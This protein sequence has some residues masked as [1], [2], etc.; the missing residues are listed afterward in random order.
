MTAIIGSLIIFCFCPL[1]GGLPLIDWLTYV[2]KGQKL[3]EM[4]TGNVSV[5]AAFYHGGT[6]VGILAVLSEAGKGVFTVLLARYFFPGEMWWE[7]MA[8]IALIIGRYWMGKGAGTT[9][10][11]WGIMVHDWAATFLTTLI[12]LSSFTIFRDRVTG[13]LLALFL[14]AFILTVRNPHDLIYVVLAWSLSG[15]MAWIFKQV[16]DDLSL[17][18]SGVKSSS[19]TMFKFFR[20]EKSLLSLNDKLDGNKVGNKAANLA[21]LRGL[22]YAVPNGWI[23]LPG[24][25]PQIILDYLDPSLENTFVVR[26][27]ALGED[28]ETASAAGQY[29]TLL[30]ISNEQEL[31]AAI[32]DCLAAY[33]HPHAVKYRR[34]K[35]QNEQGIALL[36][37]KQVKGTF[38]GVAFSRDPVNPLNNCVVIETLPGDANQIVSGKI[39]PEQYQVEVYENLENDAIKIRNREEVKSQNVP[40]F[41]IEKVAMLARDIESIYHGI[42]QDIEWSYDGETLWILQTRTITNLQPI[43]TRKIAAE[44]IPGVIS[45]L[46]WSINK[47]LTCGVWGDI[48]SLVL[49]DKAKDLDFDETARLHFQQAYFNAT[50]LGQ[51]F[52]RMGLPPES[53]EFLTRGSK[54]TKPSLISTIS[55]IP[56]LLRLAKREWTLEDDFS[57]DNQKWFKTLLKKLAHQEINQLSSTELLQNIEDILFSLKSA[58]YYSILAPLSLA[59]RQSLLKVSPE[60]LNN[61][62]TPEIAALQALEKLAE[63]TILLIHPDNLEQSD[64]LFLLLEKSN[65]GEKI[66]QQFDLIIEKY[67]YLSDVATDISIPCWQDNPNLVKTLFTQ[68]I[69]NQNKNK[70]KNK[71]QKNKKNWQVKQVQKKLNL[72]GKVTEIYS[73]L[74]AQLRWHFLEL[75]KDLAAKNIIK[76]SQDIFQLTYSEI[77]SIIKEEY[78]YSSAQIQE[79]IKERKEEF[80]INKNLK[81]IPYVLYGNITKIPENH[82]K[83]LE[84]N[85]GK[86][87]GIGASCGEVEGY[88][89]I[90]HNLQ[91]VVGITN[92]TILVIPYTDSGWG[93]LIANAG[94]IIAEVGGALSHGAIIAR[95]YGIPAV[96]NIDHATEIFQEGQRVKIDGQ[97]GIIELLED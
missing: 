70:N 4:G 78:E 65:E 13:R 10:L 8:L 22:G 71:A 61:S 49:K 57:K 52:Q 97:Q 53:L 64:D 86:I 40:D 2:F 63:E 18:E 62:V 43:W 73:Q 59:I 38:S 42:P 60:N 31:S 35:G 32:L 96:M 24:D 45:P 21:Y 41:I 79:K 23:L 68:L 81:N 85:S 1:L 26:S 9:N 6:F 25:D 20:G 36:I 27:S 17:P 58:T 95:E 47:P 72:K 84:K 55:N 46:T 50:L 91:Q 11:F 69:I 15:L 56:G 29:L 33:N 3:S 90:C 54:M 92:D 12:S 75:A 82:N 37:Q 44:V 66:I 88:I 7:L 14:L 83:K 89:K 74:L 76:E 48:F 19:K 67:G 94:G 39:T 30:N 34:D 87:Q 80:S 51:I 93:P 5:S 28:T 77:D 16:P